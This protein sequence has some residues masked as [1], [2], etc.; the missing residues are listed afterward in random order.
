MGGR[1][2]TDYVSKATRDI[3]KPYQWTCTT[4]GGDRRPVTL[5][6]LSHAQAPVPAPEFGSAGMLAHV[7]HTVKA[8][9]S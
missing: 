7:R 3:P 8:P 2:R 4:P 1:V 9:E 6:G 5:E